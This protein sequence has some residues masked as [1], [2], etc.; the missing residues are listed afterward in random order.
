MRRALP[1]LQRFD[2]LRW[3]ETESDYLI[4]Y[5]KDDVICVVNVD[6]TAAARGHLPR[7]A[8]ARGCRPSS[9]CED[10]LRDT[11]FRG[12]RA[13]TTSRSAPARAMS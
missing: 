7:P 3:L 13:G 5:A 10:V 11:T 4:A 2:N 12:S 9:A 1:A 6:P 8:G